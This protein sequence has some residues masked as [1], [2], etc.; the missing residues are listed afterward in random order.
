[1]YY[2]VFL[3]TCIL[4]LVTSLRICK[5]KQ[6]LCF[7]ARNQ[8]EFEVTDSN[9]PPVADPGAPLVEMEQFDQSPDRP[10]AVP[11]RDRPALSREGRQYEQFVDEDRI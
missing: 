4:M 8:V 2:L 5:A 1:V 9:P 6:L 10:R 3:L 7:R 11:D